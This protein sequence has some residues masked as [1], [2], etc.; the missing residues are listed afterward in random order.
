[1]T[2]KTV[3]TTGVTDTP[4]TG[5]AVDVTTVT[6]DT[7][8]T[9]TT[10]EG[11]L[12]NIRRKSGKS[13]I[14]KQFLSDAFNAV[15]ESEF[16]RERRKKAALKKIN[17]D[18]EKG[19]IPDYILEDGRI[20]GL[21]SNETKTFQTKM[22][23]VTK[24]LFSSQY[25]STLHNFRFI[26]SDKD[27]PNAGVITKAKPPIIVFSKALI[28][29]LETE[30]QLA[31]VL[32]HELTH[33]AIFDRIGK[34]GNSNPEE[35]MSD[36]W[37]V[38]LLQ[39][40]GYNPHAMLEFM[41]K[42]R[43]LPEP[44][45]ERSILRILD[46]H[47]PI[48]IRLRNIEN[49]LAIVEQKEKLNS[50][51]TAFDEDLRATVGKAAHETYLERRLRELDYAAL[52]LDDKVKATS[53][54]ILDEY[55]EF[56]EIH[57]HRNE[58]MQTH[59]KALCK[60]C[61]DTEQY[62]LLLP[63]YYALINIGP[64]LE[65]HKATKMH[66][67]ISAIA[68]SRIPPLE[69][70]TPLTPEIKEDLIKQHQEHRQEE[71]YPMGVFRDLHIAMN[72]FVN[73]KSF[74][75][76]LPHARTINAYTA[77]Y[78][79]SRSYYL[80]R[81][82]NLPD[83]SKLRHRQDIQKAL[84][85]SQKTGKPTEFSW[86]PHRRWGQSPKEGAT[87][88]LQA[89][90][91]FHIDDGMIPAARKRRALWPLPYGFS[92]NHCNYDLD[93]LTLDGDGHILG[94]RAD[95]DRRFDYD[96]NRNE[97]AFRA[98]E[99]ALLR[100]LDK[101]AAETL[102]YIDW[103]EMETD[104][105][106]F[107]EKHQALLKPQLSIVNKGHDFAAAFVEKLEELHDKDPKKYAPHIR[108]FFDGY[109]QLQ[110][111]FGIGKNQKPHPQSLPGMIGAFHSETRYQGNTMGFRKD[112]TK[113]VQSKQTYVTR[114]VSR[115]CQ[116][117]MFVDHPYIR[118]MTKFAP[119]YLD[120]RSIGM[121]LD[122]TNIYCES[123]R[124]QDDVEKIFRVDIRALL[125]Y[126]KPKT[127]QDLINTVKKLNDARNKEHP[128]SPHCFRHVADME[129]H[130]FL[131]DNKDQYLDLQ[132]L[133]DIKAVRHEGLSASVN[134]IIKI[135]DGSD[136]NDRFIMLFERQVRINAATDLDPNKTTVT[137]LI[138]RYK[139][140]CGV[141]S[142]NGSLFTRQPALRKTY[143]QTI[144]T[145]IEA[146]KHPVKRKDRLEQLLN[147]C[148]LKDPD[149]RGWAVD[150]WVKAQSTILLENYGTAYSRRLPRIADKVIQ[151]TKKSQSVNMLS[152]LL[153]AIEAGEKD[154]FMV[155]DKL[156]NSLLKKGSEDG[157][158]AA[159]NDDVMDRMSNNPELRLSML[160]FLTEPLS[161]ANALN[162]F[163]Q[164]Q[165]IYMQKGAAPSQLQSLFTQ[166]VKLPD[167]A[168][169][170]MMGITH[171]NF[172][173]MPFAAR[174][175]YIE[176][177][178]FP[179]DQTDQK[180]FDEA[181]RYV[182]DRI[183]P[184]G[185]PYTAEARK[186]LTTHMEECSKPLQRL[187]ISA[188]MTASEKK[189]TTP[190]PSFAT[191]AQNNAAQAQSPQSDIRPGQIL[192]LVLGKTGAAGGKI[193]Q[194]VHSYLQSVPTDDPNL[195]QFRDDLKASKS[196]FNVPFRWDIFD[197]IN[198]AVPQKIRQTM[199]VGRLLGAGSYGYTVQIRRKNKDTALTL[200]RP[201]VEYEAQHQFE[202]YRIT[203]EKLAKDDSK[204]APLTGILANAR[205]MAQVEADFNIGAQQIRA[206]EKLYNGYKIKAD[207]E[208]FKIRTA[209]LH[210]FG[211]EYKETAL[212][213]GVHFNDLPATTQAEKQYR[214]AAAKALFTAEISIMLSGAGFDYDRH[215]AQQRI[216]GNTITMFD[217]GS[218]MYDLKKGAVKTPTEAE[219][220]TL[221]TIIASVATDLKNGNSQVMEA[222]LAKLTDT[223]Q[224]GESADY[225]EG[226]K[227]GLLALGDYRQHMG[228]TDKA[229]NDAVQNAIMAVILS[230]SV[231]P[232]IQSAVLKAVD[233]T[234]A[235]TK[236]FKGA[237]QAAADGVIPPLASDITII[238]HGQAAFENRKNVIRAYIV[239]AVKQTFDAYMPSFLKRKNGSS[240]PQP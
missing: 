49:A 38:H 52:S 74:D 203:A 58:E 90:H 10:P 112:I 111:A 228:T 12:D 230:G 133:K 208:T 149:F 36:V 62:D 163:D 170:D 3:I 221:G 116:K 29:L 2:E 157:L 235:L 48:N 30:D 94:L 233:P 98:S 68:F 59:L 213:R 41:T 202:H 216:A 137:D 214:Q 24:R 150:Q 154:S 4:T 134:P 102:A 110:R 161:D 28:D 86:N 114:K 179:V 175:I 40:G 178:L 236:D 35:T 128:R 61:R 126:E 32:A 99:N 130:R 71:R 117:G 204:W 82:H 23:A 169:I 240:R 215:G 81:L 67:F 225:I 75:D 143:E 206:A 234:G 152:G 237:K 104:L 5:V 77:A 195:I 184:E 92:F 27:K 9:I 13:A 199:T 166:Y 1:M 96:E 194:A 37:A 185:K 7:T 171:R 135:D 165:T 93:D 89:L 207:E 173:S 91:S 136:Y 132:T 119:L 85:E 39:K 209:S 177:V 84:A 121:I 109:G 95:Y 200:L 139:S 219:K 146:I 47:P 8:G 100:N 160:N 147:E 66:T 223:R 120:M 192:S 123:P 113:W 15:S 115:D 6:T 87:E 34:H 232:V 108:K 20:A 145:R 227:R 224:Y 142:A 226:F 106:G 44:D 43:D 69:V 97:T 210:D 25:S 73:A 54:L 238:S 187:M 70:K 80:S 129:I 51:R 181:M 124:K 131:L 103:S 88:I 50:G 201:N 79:I 198:Q 17:A 31:A 122:Q 127:A 158:L 159:A 197:R 174:T 180:D 188:L 55:I 76:A 64:H 53:R 57:G 63:L 212:A 118:M 183:L 18:L 14:S 11:L 138:N 107:I 156:V 56:S 65:N 72:G 60:D 33:Q 231:D 167:E 218:L 196:D 83:F 153:N 46:P 164:L 222:L 19:I 205:E 193:L 21:Q 140:Y 191:N 144:Q 78:D 211:K 125:G 101:S 151:S 172:W 168:K 45:H 42:L 16:T 155:R 141:Q 105:W 176:R 239:T 182:L 186:I 229:R 220:H 217:H 148:D 162:A 190:A 189:E 26:I 22:E